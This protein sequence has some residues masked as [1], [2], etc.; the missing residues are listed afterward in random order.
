MDDRDRA[1]IIATNIVMAAFV[2]SL[3]AIVIAT[4]IRLFTWIVG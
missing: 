2:V 1:I 3:V 4:T